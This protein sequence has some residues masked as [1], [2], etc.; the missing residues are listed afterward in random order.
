LNSIL[1]LHPAHLLFTQLEGN[2]LAIFEREVAR[3]GFLE[4]HETAR[5][6]HR[7][8]SDIV[9]FYYK[10]RNEKLGAE[11]EATKQA[12]LVARASKKKVQ[13][14]QIAAQHKLQPHMPMGV[15]ASVMQQRDSSPDSDEEGSVWAEDEL[16]PEK[17]PSCAVCG[18]KV[19]KHW[20]KAPRSLTGNHLCYSCG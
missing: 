3:W 12:K 17:P 15:S 6:T 7:K 4:H 16:D 13:R 1:D 8:P 2:D 9:R 5:L 11:H 18:G 14:A 20:W 10:W 19:A